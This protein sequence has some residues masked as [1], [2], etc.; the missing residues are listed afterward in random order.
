VTI[1]THQVLFTPAL[2]LVGAGTNS[3]EQTLRS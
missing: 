2:R 3:I 1:H